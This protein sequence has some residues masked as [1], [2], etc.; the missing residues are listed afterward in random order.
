MSAPLLELKDVAHA[1]GSHQ[2][3]HG[4]SLSL[5][6]GDHLLIQGP[7]GSGKTTL[8]NIAGALLEPTQGQVVFSGEALTGRGDLAA[9]RLHNVGFVFQDFHLLES[10]S[11]RQNLDIVR[12]ARGGSPAHTIDALLAPLG[13]DDRLDVPVRRLSRGERQRVALARAFANG[14][15][16]VLA[17]EP[18][19]SLDPSHASATLDHL[20]A[21]A[22][23]TGATVVMASHD[24]KLSNRADW[25][26][27]AHV[28]GGRLSED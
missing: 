28:E 13:L 25:T 19:A 23:A 8:L 9:H 17:D 22:K 21:L 7:S 2:V 4:V 27:R 14:P 24:S 18:T 11:P 5:A 3:L 15:R 12:C 1:F 26:R 16:L 20:F 6:P 10:L